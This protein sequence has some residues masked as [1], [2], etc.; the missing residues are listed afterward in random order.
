MCVKSLL[1]HLDASEEQQGDKVPTD[2][3]KGGRG[4]F[5]QLFFPVLLSFFT[6]STD[7]TSAQSLSQSPVHATHTITPSQPPLP[8]P[9]HLPLHTLKPLTLAL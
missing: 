6:D 7:N 9:N 3:A 8:Y 5:S 1:L 2:D 4:K